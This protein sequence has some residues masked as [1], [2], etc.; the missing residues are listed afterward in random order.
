MTELMHNCSTPD[1]EGREGS[2]H[3]GPTQVVE[4]LLTSTEAA[5][6]LRLHSKTVQELAHAGKLPGFQIGRCWRFRRSDLNIWIQ[7][8]V[9]GHTHCQSL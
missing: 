6:L 7:E 8:K 4:S 2:E 9:S 5:R 3:N 1:V